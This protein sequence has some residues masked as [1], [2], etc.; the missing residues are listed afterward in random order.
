MPE[1]TEKIS[2]GDTFETAME[3][4]KRE[5]KSVLVDFSAAPM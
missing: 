5:G 4:A 1:Q 2:W 3:R